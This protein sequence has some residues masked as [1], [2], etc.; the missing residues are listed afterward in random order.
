M[1]ILL[2]VSRNPENSGIVNRQLVSLIDSESVYIKNL[3][4]R[5]IHK[6]KGITDST[7]EYILSK[8]SHDPNYV[9]RMVCSQVADNSKDRD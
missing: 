6:V 1:R 7:K 3:I 2:A 5:N 4:V 8:C 9:V